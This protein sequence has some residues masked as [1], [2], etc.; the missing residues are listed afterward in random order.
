MPLSCCVGPS[1][2][3][4]NLD[5]GWAGTGR[6]GGLFMIMDQRDQASTRAE[7]EYEGKWEREENFSFSG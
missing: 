5:R 6:A 3:T 2:C 7:G 4:A 1:S